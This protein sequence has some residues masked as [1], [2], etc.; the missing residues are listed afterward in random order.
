[1]SEFPEGCDREPTISTAEWTD[2]VSG[3]S[4]PTK[5]KSK[6]KSVPPP[7][8]PI[9][10]EEVTRSPIVSSSDSWSSSGT[11]INT[12]IN[13]PSKEQKIEE[14]ESSFSSPNAPLHNDL[15]LKKASAPMNIPQPSPSVINFGEEYEDPVTRPYAPSSWSSSS[16]SPHQQKL[17][18]SPPMVQPEALIKPKDEK[19]APKATVLSSPFS[20][21]SSTAERW[22]FPKI[23]F[24]MVNPSSS[25]PE[26]A[27]NT[28]DVPKRSSA[29]KKSPTFMDDTIDRTLADINSVMDEITEFMKNAEDEQPQEEGGGD[30]GRGKK[31]QIEQSSDEDTDSHYRRRNED[32]NNASPAPAR[33]SA[34]KKKVTVEPGSESDTSSESDSSSSGSDVGASK[35]KGKSP[36]PRAVSSSSSPPVTRGRRPAKQSS[37]PPARKASPSPSPPPR[38]STSSSQKPIKTR[39]QREEEEDAADGKE[40]DD[41]DEEDEEGGEE[42]DDMADFN[43]TPPSPFGKKKKKPS[44]HHKHHHHKHHTP[45]PK[46]KKRR[47]SSSS[48]SSSSSPSSHRKDPKRDTQFD[49]DMD[50]SLDTINRLQGQVGSKNAKRPSHPPPRAH[51][52]RSPTTNNKKKSKPPRSSKKTGP[53]REP[54][55]N[56][57]EKSILA[58]LA[59]ANNEK[60]RE[61]KKKLTPRLVHMLYGH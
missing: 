29:R 9:T 33:S 45:S 14:S 25:S 5:S 32:D 51:R 23:D 40:N 4:P 41:E 27:K 20:S 21:S 8:K 36:P 53:P 16:L 42:M 50:T 56:T 18:P 60:R 24:P 13:K 15:P 58:E 28:E 7:P 22:G 54:T 48:S 19:V 30:K 12:V 46:S 35:R 38:K 37:P 26:P 17:P 34:P 10:V 59:S 44:S 39:A 55:L 11:D 43:P 31:K 61:L 49:M 52:R 3:K 2:P 1:M 57:Y 47:D 6:V